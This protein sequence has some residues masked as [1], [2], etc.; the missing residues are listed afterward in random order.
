ML[1]SAPMD[2]ASRPSSEQYQDSTRWMLVVLVAVSVLAA[3]VVAAADVPGLVGNRWQVVGAA[4][5]ALTL[6]ALLVA[7]FVVLRALD[8]I[9]DDDPGEAPVVVPAVLA[10]TVVAPEPL[11]PVAE[12]AAAVDAESSTD[13]EGEAPATDDVDVDDQTGEDPPAGEVAPVA[14]VTAAPGIL[15]PAVEGP[16]RRAQRHAATR[17]RRSRSV[18]TVAIVLAFLG[19]TGMTVAAV[20]DGNNI[21]ERAR[22]ALQSE[23][24]IEDE[25]PITEPQAVAVQ[26]T[27]PGLRRIAEEMGC[28]GQ[29]I[30]LR[31]VQG[32]AVSGTYRNPVVVLFGPT[33]ACDDVQL[34]LA[35]RDGF[36][37]PTGGVFAA[38]A[39]RPAATG[40]ATPPTSVAG[41]A[42]GPVAA[43][44]TSAAP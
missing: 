12:E 22:D 17:Y 20:A 9:A 38:T 36:V 43:T 40:F 3:G 15:A 27:T 8:P 35:P 13:S 32:W 4:S 14:E 2:D 28:T 26:F 16:S 24:A 25:G 31:P 7:V 10:D 34:A 5:V 19:M 42:G 29:Q 23:L 1:R 21:E 30:G 33:A 6:G 39:N 11:V 44:P 37:Y 41:A 18:A